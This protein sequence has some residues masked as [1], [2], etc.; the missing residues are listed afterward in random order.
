[1]DSDPIIITF[2]CTGNTCRSPMAEFLM[3]KLLADH[4]LTTIEVQSAGIAPAAELEFPEEA[5]L[6]LAD[7][8][9]I[10]I[11]HHAKP[12][13]NDMA[14]SSHLILTM[15]KRHLDWVQ[16]RFPEAKK[17]TYLLTDYAGLNKEEIEDPYGQSLATYKKILTQ[18]KQALV[19]LVEKIQKA[20]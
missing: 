11:R 14:S 1:M 18:I 20:D 13:T 19:C 15:E 9:V 16:K 5:R 6:A 2:I 8:G 17:K 3:R 4:H 10:A 12:L 7:E